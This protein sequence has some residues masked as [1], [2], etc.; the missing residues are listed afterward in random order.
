VRKPQ[1]RER[2]LVVEDEWL[3]LDML[4]DELE[5]AGYSVKATSSG[6]GAIR[7]L[8]QNDFDLIITDINLAG[9][10]DGWAVAARGRELRPQVPVI[11]TT[12]YRSDRSRG[13]DDAE[14]VPKPYAPSDVVKIAQF[15][16]AA[17]R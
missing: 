14:F 4:R 1:N 8:D 9:E 13:V 17:N 10:I 3:I 11:Y 2:V 15:L 16:T 12:A 7:S 5:S 6:E